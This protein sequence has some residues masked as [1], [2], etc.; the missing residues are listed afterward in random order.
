MQLEY[1]NAEWEEKNEEESDMDAITRLHEANDKLMEVNT[2]GS[3][4]TRGEGWEQE[5]DYN[6]IIVNP[7]AQCPWDKVEEGPTFQPKVKRGATWGWEVNPND[8]QSHKGGCNL[9]GDTVTE[10]F[11][12]KDGH[13]R[14]VYEWIGPRE[15]HEDE[16][17]KNAVRYSNAGVKKQGEHILWRT[18]PGPWEYEEYYA[19]LWL[20]FSQPYT[21]GPNKLKI[22]GY[23]PGEDCPW[24]GFWYA[25]FKFL[26]RLGKANVG[27]VTRWF[28]QVWVNP[29]I[30]T[31]EE[32]YTCAMEDYGYFVGWERNPV[33]CL[34][35][36]EDK[37]VSGE[38]WDIS[39]P[40]KRDPTR[41]GLERATFARPTKSNI[42]NDGLKRDEQERDAKGRAPGP[43]SDEAEY[44]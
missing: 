32:W 21:G 29:R 4:E 19:C 2:Q 44:E 36:L 30:L 6:P 14:L 38:P 11:L 42:T 43:Q 37:E 18:S 12:W 8:P 31:E 13:L 15:F 20:P 3:E 35:K 40:W 27:H 9:Y 33:Y 39:K 24:E 1:L 25:Q 26:E 5:G 16:R 17:R 10:K 41:Y 22:F 28:C 34:Y 23:L 7:N